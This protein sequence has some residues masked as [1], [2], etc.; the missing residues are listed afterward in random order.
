MV[1]VADGANIDVG[2]GALEGSGVAAGSIVEGGV[3]QR[4]EGA[5]AAESASSGEKGA[6]KVRHDGNDTDQLRIERQR[7]RE[8]RGDVDMCTRYFCPAT[9]WG[10]MMEHGSSKL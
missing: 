1:D 7:R 9:F 5:S 10:K 8:E 4:V 3:V 6:S 2:L